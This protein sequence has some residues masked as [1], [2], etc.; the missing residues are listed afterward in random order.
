[1]TASVFRD[2][3]VRA[4]VAAE[5]ISNA[6]SQMTY[7][8]LPWFV[9]T[10]TGSPT[11][12]SIVVAAELAPVAFFGLVSGAVTSRLGA[13]RT[14][15]IAD[16]S[17]ALLLAAIPTLHLLGALSFAALVALVFVVGIFMVPHA[18]AQRV[19]IPELVGEDEA[20]VGQAMSL[21]Q[22]AY[23]G[24]GI[25]G[26]AVG[27]VLIALI[28]ETNVLYVDAATYAVSFLLIAGWVRPVRAPRADDEPSGVIAGVRFLF[29][30]RLLRA[31]MLSITGMNIVWTAMSVV[32]PVLVLER[33][34]DRPEILGWIFG[35]FGVGSVV[36]AVGSYRVIGRFDRIVLTSTAS[37][38]Q[39]AVMWMLLPE[40]SWPVVAA[41]AAIAGL[42]FPVLNAC[43]VTVRTMRT[44]VS[45]RPTVH[46][47]AVTVAM[48]LA[49]LGALAAGP[50]LERFDLAPVLGVILFGNTLC[51]LVMAAAG[52]RDRRAV[53]VEPAASTARP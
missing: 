41:S 7:I 18:S 33:Y 50:A 35:A 26:P 36:G 8:V 16:S 31:W 49:P 45:L 11:R 9:L 27:G 37:A 39:T 1:M 21:M 2:R 12:T 24:A 15:L 14:F 48:I 3:G 23:A 29:G 25:A 30:D 4:L 22:T 28:G 34:G 52:L 13:R 47:A 43:V 17:R 20:R 40:L 42:F 53:T 38:G 46:T 32:F 19:V 44:P 5:G 51:G 10:T 6:G